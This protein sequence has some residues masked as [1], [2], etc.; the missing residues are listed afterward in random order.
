MIGRINGFIALCQNKDEFPAFLSSHCIIHQKVLAS[1]R[2]NTK[3][4]MDIVFKIVYSIR[5]SFLK[6]RLFQQQLGEGQ[7]KLLLHTDIRWL[8]RGKFLQQFCNLLP[9][10]Y[11]IFHSKMENMKI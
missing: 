7:P 5:G 9:D 4:I 2:L 11:R 3:Q 8:R 6:W 10:K 1:K